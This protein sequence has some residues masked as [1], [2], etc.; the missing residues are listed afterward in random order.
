MRVVVEDN[1]ALPGQPGAG[2]GRNTCGMTHQ[3]LDDEWHPAERPIRGVFERTL[4]RSISD[5]VQPR[6]D[7]V[8]RLARRLLHFL[9]ADLTLPNEFGQ[10]HGVARRVLSDIHLGSSGSSRPESRSCP[11]AR[12][13]HKSASTS[14]CLATS[15]S[16]TR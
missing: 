6:I 2:S 1:A 10:T 9:L 11:S 7:L 3:I 4:P 8:D 5:R 14:R 15:S 12:L 13:F 16:R